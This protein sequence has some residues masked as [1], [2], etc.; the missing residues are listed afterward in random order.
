MFNTFFSNI[1]FF[2]NSLFQ[3]FL[4][5]GDCPTISLKEFYSTSLRGRCF[6]LKNPQFFSKRSDDSHPSSTALNEI[7]VCFIDKVPGKLETMTSKQKLDFLVASPHSYR[8]ESAQHYKRDEN[9]SQQPGFTNITAIKG[10]GLHQGTRE[11]KM[12][13]AVI[14]N[15]YLFCLMIYPYLD[16]FLKW[17]ITNKP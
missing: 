1:C 2:I 8:D 16:L 7:V 9:N 14:L 15:S 3:F 6:K 5:V 13:S 11:Q 17:N 12:L 4:K 10:K